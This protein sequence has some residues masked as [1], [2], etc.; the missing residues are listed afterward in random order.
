MKATGLIAKYASEEEDKVSKE[1]SIT[2][3]QFLRLFTDFAFEGFECVGDYRA[4]TEHKIGYF[5]NQ[6]SIKEMK[7]IVSKEQ[8]DAMKDLEEWKYIKQN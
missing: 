1:Y 4:C 3:E 5:S 2:A 6:K 8:Y 7:I